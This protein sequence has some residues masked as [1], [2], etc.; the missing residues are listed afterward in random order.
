MNDLAVTLIQAFVRPDRQ[1][2]YIKLLATAKGRA[3]FRSTLAHFRDLDLRHA[4]RVVPSNLDVPAISKEL[5]G[6]GAP[7]ECY[8]LSESVEL[9]GQTLPLDKALEAVVGR[10]MGTFI[11]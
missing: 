4:R 1:D 8:L 7:G 9:D 11:S 6:R 5:K 2:R 3:K 10:G